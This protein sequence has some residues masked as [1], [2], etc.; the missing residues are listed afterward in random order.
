MSSDFLL[1]ISLNRCVSKHRTTLLVVPHF[2]SVHRINKSVGK[3]CQNTCTI[4]HT[5]VRGNPLGVTFRDKARATTSLTP[6]K[7][8]FSPPTPSVGRAT[9]TKSA[10][11]KIKSRPRLCQKH[12]RKVYVALGVTTAKTTKNSR[13]RRS[14]FS[15]FQLRLLTKD[16]PG[17]RGG[18]IPLPSSHLSP[19]LNARC[20]SC[21]PQKAV[22]LF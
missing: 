11:G 16:V 7:D 4:R 10:P 21:I 20:W 9:A 13:N 5:T 6:R 15:S 12:T 1:V 22:P 8:A 17:K 18:G 14:Q 3:S 19:C 2:D